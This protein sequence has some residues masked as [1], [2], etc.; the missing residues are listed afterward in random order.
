MLEGIKRW[1]SGAGGAGTAGYEG[2]VAWAQ[3]NNSTFRGA[4]DDGFVIDG[5]LDPTAWRLEWGP[6]QRPYIAGN[7]L[8]LRADTGVETELQ[9]LVL[10]R[11][12]QEHL[13]KSIFEQYVEDVQ[14]RI[15][16]QTPPEMRWL[17][18]FPK[19]PSSDM[20]ALRDHFVAVGNAKSWLQAWL[21]GGLS[22]ALALRATQSSLPLVL[23]IGR[24]RL[25]L[26]TALDVPT[27]PELQRVLAL[28]ETALREARRVANE[29]PRGLPD[30]RTS[31]SGGSDW[32]ATS[33][34]SRPGDSTPPRG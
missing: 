10:S 16:N 21:R 15:D 32:D 17:V 9:L 25:M 23:M 18:M 33:T 20:G 13:E 27:V 5:R 34:S 12:L 22:Q 31:P 4:Q 28:F 11:T 14:T 24:G 7:E 8:R 26:R 2:I 19:L 30:S 1:L 3:S 6:S 29:N